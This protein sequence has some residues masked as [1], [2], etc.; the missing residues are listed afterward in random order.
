MFGSEVERASRREFSDNRSDTPE[1][2]VI[3]KGAGPVMMVWIAGVLNN[4]SVIAIGRDDIEQLE[5][6]QSEALAIYDA[7]GIRGGIGLG[8]MQ[9]GIASYLRGDYELARQRW[10]PWRYCGGRR[11]HAARLYRRA[12]LKACATPVRFGDRG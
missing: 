7:A 2:S 9:L 10:R 3:A 12:G 8:L 1:G 11:S 4:L 5:A 6:R